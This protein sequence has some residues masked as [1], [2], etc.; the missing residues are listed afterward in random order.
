MTVDLAASATHVIPFAGANAWIAEH[1]FD[2]DQVVSASIEI[3]NVTQ[4]G[5]EPVIVAW[6]EVE[7][8]CTTP[9]GH[10]Y[11][12]DEQTDAVTA[13]STVPLR[14]WPPLQPAEGD[15]NG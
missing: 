5:D 7:W 15:L 12:N 2:P 1:G 4:H 3:G 9:D 6:L 14:S 8:Y 10:R 11:M 13:H